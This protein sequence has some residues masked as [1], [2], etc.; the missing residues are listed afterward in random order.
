MKIIQQSLCLE[1][2]HNVFNATS[3]YQLRVFQWF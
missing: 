3:A 1:L 2:K